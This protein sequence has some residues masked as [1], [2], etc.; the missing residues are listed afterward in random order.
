MLAQ[1]VLSL[2][3]GPY[4]SSADAEQVATVVLA[5]AGH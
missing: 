1:H 4:L 5:A 3:M 2:P